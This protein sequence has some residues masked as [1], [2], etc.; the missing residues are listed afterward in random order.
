MP[1]LQSLSAK[2]ENIFPV[3]MI[4][5]MELHMLRVLEWKTLPPTSYNLLTCIMKEWDMY[6]A[7]EFATLP[8]NSIAAFENMEE[9]SRLFHVMAY[10]LRMILLMENNKASFNRYQAMIQ[11]LDLASLDFYINKFSINH[12]V[13]G[14]MYIMCSRFFEQT[15]YSLFKWTGELGANAQ[16]GFIDYQELSGNIILSFLART[17][18]NVSLESLE[19]PIRFLQVYA[20]TPVQVEMVDLQAVRV[21]F[22]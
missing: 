15:D 2:A 17:L 12:I 21:T 10:N 18:L 22:I 3:Q 19:L 8:N 6:L 7:T 4:R 5:R 9:G 11:V 16:E 20:A 13:A 1:S 14:L